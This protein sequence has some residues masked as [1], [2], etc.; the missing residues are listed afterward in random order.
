MTELVSGAI[1]DVQRISAG[2]RPA[3]LDDIGLSAAIEH[4]CQEFE[5][6]T[7]IKCNVR[8]DDFQFEEKDINL[9]IFRIVQESLT[10][11][12]RHSEAKNVT[13]DY[14][15]TG[16]SVMLDIVD[17][18]KGMDK[19]IIDDIDSLG[20]MGIKERVAQCKG[21]VSITSDHMKGT[22]VCVVLP[23][24]QDLTTDN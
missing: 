14:C 13:I 2:L 6:R 24:K 12:A 8:L 20:I 17:D 15:I 21:E 9:A 5:A 18:G 3:L 7:G 1:S 16:R 11:V 23:M 19:K 22:R 4:Q 10:N